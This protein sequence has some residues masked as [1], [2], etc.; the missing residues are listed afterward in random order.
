MPILASWS[1][2]LIQGSR[3]VQAAA[4][5]IHS[6]TH[7]AYW[8]WSYTTRNPTTTKLYCSLRQ[9]LI[10]LPL[11]YAEP[12]RAPQEPQYITPIII[13][14][15]H[16]FHTF[17]NHHHRP[18]TSHAPKSHISNVPPFPP[19]PPPQT[20]SPHLSHLNPSDGSPCNPP[21]TVFHKSLFKPLLPT[22]QVPNSTRPATT[23]RNARIP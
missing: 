4:L 16:H 23:P 13:F 18:S 19:P 10:C 20:N 2:S 12:H 9:P 14:C 3:R 21:L 6:S 15:N 11:P 1:N 22:P 7:R 5:P 8:C 17:L